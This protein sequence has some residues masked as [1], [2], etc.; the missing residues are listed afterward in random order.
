MSRNNPDA[1]GSSAADTPHQ[2]LV[3]AETGF[4][5]QVSEIGIGKEMRKKNSP[6]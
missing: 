1:T 2:D 6:I 4:C 5:L 3:I